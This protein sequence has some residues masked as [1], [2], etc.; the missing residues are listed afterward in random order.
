MP[1]SGEH[2][3][4][5]RT[6]DVAAFLVEKLALT[7]T[8][9][10]LRGSGFRERG[11]GTFELHVHGMDSL[12]PVGASALDTKAH[13]HQRPAAPLVLLA[14][15][16]ALR[17]ANCEALQCS[18]FA[19]TLEL[20]GAPH[21]YSVCLC[22]ITL[23]FCVPCRHKLRTHSTLKLEG[24]IYD[25]YQ[26]G[27]FF[28]DISLHFRAEGGADPG[29]KIDDGRGVCSLG[30]ILFGGAPDTASGSSRCVIEVSEGPDSDVV[31]YSRP[32][33]FG[34]GIV[35]TNTLRHPVCYVANEELLILWIRVL[36]NDVADVRA[37]ATENT[38]GVASAILANFETNE[39]RMPTLLEVQDA[40]KRMQVP[41]LHI[42]MPSYMNDA[43]KIAQLKFLVAAG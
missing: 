6:P 9:E 13:K 27:R 1:L 17:I 5:G 32:L 11:V 37:M 20:S 23:L 10:G 33:Y 3:V 2:I 40:Y 29:F 39:L 18:L 19:D 38:A 24:A 4:L 22:T 14:F 7:C 21:S 30:Y 41:P 42:N 43:N 8:P 28:A 34:D 31:G 12:L 36:P 15:C 26:T 16:E 35:T 25:A